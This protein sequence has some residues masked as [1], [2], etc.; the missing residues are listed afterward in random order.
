MAEN[1]S[2]VDRQQRSKSLPATYFRTISNRGLWQMPSEPVPE[3]VTV[4]LIDSPIQKKPWWRR[5]SSARRADSTDKGR[6]LSLPN[7]VPRQES[8][9]ESNE[10]GQ[11]PVGWPARFVNS[12]RGTVRRMRQLMTN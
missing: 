10:S 5:L 7:N 6:S 9:P 1:A 3:P 12:L 11:E 8:S 4:S 2:G